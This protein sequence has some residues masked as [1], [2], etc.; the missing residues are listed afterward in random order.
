LTPRYLDRQTNEWRDGDSIF[1]TCSVWR[2]AAENV[3]ESL[4]GGMRVIVVGRLKQHSYQTGTVCEVEVDE[5]GP[6][7]R[8]TTARVTKNV[9]GSVPAGPGT[10]T[11]APTEDLFTS[12]E[13]LFTP[14]A[15]PGDS[16]AAT[17]DRKAP[18]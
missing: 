12:A 4:R 2:R 13:D 7:L 17:E 3:V 5:V 11:T 6:S 14:A 16:R 1:L 18:F 9:R 10:E 8:H 15:S